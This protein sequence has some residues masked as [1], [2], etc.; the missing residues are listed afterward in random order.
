MSQCILERLEEGRLEELL[1]LC[2]RE[3][4][5]ARKLVV[6]RLDLVCGADTPVLL[7]EWQIARSHDSSHPSTNQQ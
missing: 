2:V 7:I 6:E 3:R 4:L 1:H 5:R